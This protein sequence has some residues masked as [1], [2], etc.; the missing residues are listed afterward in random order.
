MQNGMA[1]M[2]N[3]PT[4]F[5]SVQVNGMGQKTA[6]PFIV[7][8]ILQIIGAGIVTWMLLQT[9]GLS[10]KQRVWFVTLYGIA[11]GVLGHPPCLELVGFVPKLRILHLL[12][13]SRR[14]VPSRTFCRKNL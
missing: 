5:A 9:R 4:M 8:L 12:R 1:M 7:S 11:I 3:G 10:Y 2:Q 14:L 13:S 6:R